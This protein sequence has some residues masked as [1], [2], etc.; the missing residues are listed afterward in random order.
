MPEPLKP[1]CALCDEPAY[2]PAELGI[3][4]DKVFLH[5]PVCFRQ[6]NRGQVALPDGRWWKQEPNPKFD[7]GIAHYPAGPWVTENSWA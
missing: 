2:L 3:E 7:D 5:H 1:P 4:G 6:V